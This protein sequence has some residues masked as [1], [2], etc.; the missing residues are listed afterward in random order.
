MSTAPVVEPDIGESIIILFSCVYDPHQLTDTINLLLLL[1]QGEGAESKQ[2][3]LKVM[4]EMIYL[5]L[6]TCP[7][8]ISSSFT[9]IVIFYFTT[10]YFTLLSY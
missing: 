2:T 4:R 8:Y 6:G 1:A 3:A 9:L 5:G 7:L 10:S